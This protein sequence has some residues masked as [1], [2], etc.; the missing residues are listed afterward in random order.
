MTAI[1]SA[2]S[3]ALLHFL[4]QGVAIGFLLSIELF[5]LRRRT[6][7]V[8][9]LA[10]CTALAFMAILPAVTAWTLYQPTTPAITAGIATVTV[11]GHT[12]TTHTNQPDFTAVWISTLQ[13]WAVPVWSLGVLLFSIR[14]VWGCRQITRMRRRGAM[15]DEAIRTLVAALARR[16][17]ITQQVRVLIAAD[18]ESPSV[19]G[20]IRPV[21]LIPAAALL[22]LTAEQLEAVLAHEL[23]HIRRHDYL[24]N[25][26]QT[27]VETL[28]F[29]HPAVWWVSARMRHERE[30]CCDDLAVGY[31]GDA[32][33]YARALT[34]LERLRV[35]PA[36][37]M[38]S[39]SG[40]MLYR[41]QRLLG[42]G[43][44]EYA[45]SKFPGIL[46]LLLAL[47]CFGLNIHWAHGQQAAT[48]TFHS[49]PVTVYTVEPALADDAGVT[50]DLGGAAVAHRS[51]IEYPGWALERKIGGTVTAEATL[52]ADASVVDA[53]ITSGPAELRRYVLQ[54]VLDWRFASQYAN[55]VLQIRVQFDHAAAAAAPREAGPTHGYALILRSNELNQL[56]VQHFQE[57]EAGAREARGQLAESARMNA[58]LE[59][60]IQSQSDLNARRE[61]EL[62]ARAELNEAMQNRSVEQIRAQV[63]ELEN[64]QEPRAWTATTGEPNSLAGR[65]LARI[66]IQGK[67]DVGLLPHL[68]VQVGNAITQ[69]TID[70]VTA[71][72]K[73]FDPTL[74]VHFLPMERGLLELRISGPR[75]AK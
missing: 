53:R 64:T 12:A 6:A 61:Q 51:R 8:R 55:A 15:P 23:A 75:M 29:Y 44:Q 72:V 22:G 14:L 16:L 74:E 4:W 50:V 66:S 5:L 9:Y 18:G 43:R 42:A 30:L 68:G 2:L 58:E 31:C 32:V 56:A 63:Q 41:V 38:G 73:T 35:A 17:G 26:V 21:V 65:E 25:L 60:E 67:V 69:Q 71:A 57:A 27:L 52:N 70:S 13:T 59:R 36:L 37:A 54:S 46:A 39:N 19:V 34:R 10:C 47:A 11:A 7:H 48:R 20:W 1:T 28:L 40:A 62:A 33:C 3:S 24:V 45:P 49:E